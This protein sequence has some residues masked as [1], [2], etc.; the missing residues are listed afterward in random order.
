MTFSILG[1]CETSGMLGLAIASSSVC[2]GSHCPWIRSG[3]GA[4]TVQYMADPA[5]GTEVLNL[6]DS[7]MSAAN[8][9]A[10]V[11]T[12]RPHAEFRQVAA[13]DRNGATGQFTGGSVEEISATMEGTNCVAS[14][15]VLGAGEVP[16]AMIDCFEC[17]TREHLAERL[18]AALRAGVDAGGEDDPTHSAALLVVHERSW[19]LVNLR[20]DWS[21]L[22]PVESLT[23]LWSRY[24][25]EMNAYV[26]WAIDPT[27]QQTGE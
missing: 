4:V 22:C 25:P 11:M 13:I 26:A 1:Y 15:N 7:G 21:D 14:G 12:G 2:V 17:E 3:V 16:K 23:D 9:V 5:I 18:M 27:E 20:I 19:P 10:R 6:L 24:E 8:A